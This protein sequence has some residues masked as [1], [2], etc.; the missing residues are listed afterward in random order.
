MSGQS[1]IEADNGRDKATSKATP[2]AK[3][4]VHLLSKV[5]GQA[6]TSEFT[7]GAQ[8]HRA[9]S[10]RMM[11]WRSGE[12]KLGILGRQPSTG[13]TNRKSATSP[14]MAVLTSAKHH[15]GAALA[16]L[17]CALKVSTSFPKFGLL[18]DDSCKR[19]GM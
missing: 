18:G 3:G 14:E 4:Q 19:E 7:G 12:Q 15:L 6:H 8:L 13:K 9:V 2:G 5:Q 17:C 11:G 10:G 16:R 1:V